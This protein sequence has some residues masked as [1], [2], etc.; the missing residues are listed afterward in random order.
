MFAIADKCDLGD[1]AVIRVKS[2]A[3]EPCAVATISYQTAKLIGPLQTGEF[4]LGG[5]FRGRCAWYQP[6]SLA[7]FAKCSGNIK[8]D[9][10]TVRPETIQPPRVKTRIIRKPKES[11]AIPCIDIQLIAIQRKRTAAFADQKPF[12]M[13]VDQLPKCVRVYHS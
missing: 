6:D 1:A 2:D 5:Q 13:A 3:F 12:E 9:L 11:F 7:V 8:L 4:D 10:V